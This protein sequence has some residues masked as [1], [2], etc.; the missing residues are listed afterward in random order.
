[1]IVV[2]NTKTAADGFSNS[3]VLGVRYVQIK[4]ERGY[5]TL[6]AITESGDEFEFFIHDGESISVVE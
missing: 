2:N 4:N 1:M 6:R 3:V 5:T